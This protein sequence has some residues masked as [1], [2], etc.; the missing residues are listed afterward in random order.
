[1]VMMTIMIVTA[2][3]PAMQRLLSFV[4]VDDDDDDDD[5]NDCDIPCFDCVHTPP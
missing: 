1:M 3:E 5:D 2:G 4:D